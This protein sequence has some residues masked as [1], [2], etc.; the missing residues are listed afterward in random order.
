MK[1][2]RAACWGNNEMAVEL[3][4]KYTDAKD[5]DENSYQSTELAHLV[6]LLTLQKI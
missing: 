6:K 1:V 4:L 2:G 3:V 5:F